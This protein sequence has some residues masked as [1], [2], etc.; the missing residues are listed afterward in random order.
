MAKYQDAF[1]PGSVSAGIRECARRWELIESIVPSS[2]MVLDVGSNLG[3]FGIRM[4]LQSEQVGVVSLEANQINAEEQAKIVRSHGM[5]RVCV[6][7]AAFNAQVSRDW[8]KVCDWFDL[9]LLL[10]IIHW[11][12]DPAQ[13][14]QDLSKMSARMIIE[15]PDAEDRGA[16]GQTHLQ[17]WRDP[18]EWT[19]KAT[20]RTVCL[21]AAAKGIL[22]KPHHT[23]FSLKDRSAGSL[24]WRIGTASTP[25]QT[26]TTT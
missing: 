11:F 6:I 25:I 15:V 20:G 13:V 5:T 12:D 9:T 21:S 2:G 3:Y 16:C 22:Q 14:V 23:S 19:R 26:A 8:V 17:D 1:Y 24:R 7:N 10:S 18:L 4:A